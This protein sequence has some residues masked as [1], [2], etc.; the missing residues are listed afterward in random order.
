[1]PASST[2]L[3]LWLKDEMMRFWL[4]MVKVTLTFMVIPSKYLLSTVYYI[5]LDCHRCKVNFTW[6]VKAYNNDAVIPVLKKTNLN[7]PF[8]NL[9]KALLKK[10]FRFTNCST[11]FFQKWNWIPFF[12]ARYIL[13]PSFGYCAL[14][15]TRLRCWNSFNVTG[16][17]MSHRAKKSPHSQAVRS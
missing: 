3:P 15:W 17:E 7:L 10:L 14:K 4:P 5:S 1:M 13:L 12:P 6:M 9:Q 16:Q 2:F 8:R 11:F